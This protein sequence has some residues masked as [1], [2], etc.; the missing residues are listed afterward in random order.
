M[1]DFKLQIEKGCECHICLQQLVEPKTLLCHHSFCAECLE[2]LLEFDDNGSATIE[3]PLK[4]K[5]VTS[6]TSNDTIK[7]LKTNYHLVHMLDLLS[8]EQSR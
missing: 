5:M 7:S 3:C 2:M 6:L 4:C 1:E 8:D